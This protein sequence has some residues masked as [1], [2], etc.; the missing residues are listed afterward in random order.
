VFLDP[1]AG[2]GS[3]VRAR[4]VLPYK[5]ATFSDLA[6]GKPH[7][8]VP[9]EIRRRV[10]VL[11]EDALELP[12]ISTGSVS[13]IVTDPP[14]GDHHRLEVDFST[15]ARR[16]LT[17]FDRVLDPRHGR[18]VLLLSRRA[19]EVTHGLWP[20]A[21]LRVLRSYRLLVNGHPATAQIGGRF[22]IKRG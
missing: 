16:M 2:S 1:F 12:S 9:S 22:D 6:V 5:R 15:F 20:A 11:S 21:N 4:M 3:I 8:R 14:W 7:L 19:A 13:S 18:L 17:S 10:T